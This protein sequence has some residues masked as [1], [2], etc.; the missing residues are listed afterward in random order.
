MMV[1]RSASEQIDSHA[2]KGDEG[3]LV[4]DQSLHCLFATSSP[5]NPRRVVAH[6]VPG[7]LDWPVPM[8]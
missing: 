1:N 7:S 4:V 6:V 8:P 2:G 5:C 3:A